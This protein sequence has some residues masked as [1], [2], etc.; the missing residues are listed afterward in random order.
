[1]AIEFNGSKKDREMEAL[2]LLL[3]G[4]SDEY[5][6]RVLEYVR[7]A[8]V[9]AEDSTF[10]L[11]V[12]LGNLDVALVDLPKAIEANGK[13]SIAEI[14]KMITELRTM[15]QLAAKQ[16]QERID[17]IN[18]AEGRIQQQLDTVSVKMTETLATLKKY[19]DESSK[20]LEFSR[21]NYQKL[22]EENYTRHQ[23]LLSKTEKLGQ[24]LEAE[25]QLRMSKPWKNAVN[26]PPLMLVA[27]IVL[28]LVIG[29]LIGSNFTNKESAN[30]DRLRYQIYDT[31]KKPQE[32]AAKELLI[33]ENNKKSRK[34]RG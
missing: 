16:A 14:S 15:F 10:I 27:V 19:R 11:M 29:L 26:L 13:K 34:N 4:K 12:A 23:Q 21:D 6:G 2:D 18:D 9:D 24:Q 30:I 5:K 33:K 20:V 7:D 17:S 22:V 32:D 31:F 28:P 8:K 1:M 3:K 25:R